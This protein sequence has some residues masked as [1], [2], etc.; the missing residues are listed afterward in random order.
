MKT[1]LA[2]LAVV[3][4]VLVGAGSLSACTPQI[5][6]VKAA[7]QQIGQPYVS[8]GESRAEG[9]FDCSGLTYYAWKQ[10]GVTLPRSSSA[11]YSWTKR[12]SRADLKPGDLV[13][14]SS[15]RSTGSISHVALYAGSG[16]IIQARKPGM[17]AEQADLNT[18]WTSNLVGYGRIPASAL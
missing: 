15:S 6:A 18:W 1:R 13:F 3:A 5:T 14:Y 10:A 17:P 2:S 12:I 4:L 7:R 9:G 8:G 11:Q 16:K